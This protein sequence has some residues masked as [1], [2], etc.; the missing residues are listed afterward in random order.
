MGLLD[1][2]IGRVRKP[3]AAVARESS[4]A[5][6]HRTPRF[7]VT[8]VGTPRFSSVDERII[9]LAIMGADEHGRQIDRWVSPALPETLIGTGTT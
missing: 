9:E 1:R 7:M 6:P 2:L 3:S 5:S 8:E 4:Q